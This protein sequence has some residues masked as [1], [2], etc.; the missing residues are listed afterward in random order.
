[1]D[2]LSPGKEAFYRFEDV[3]RTAEQQMTDKT[4]GVVCFG[5]DILS[6]QIGRSGLRAGGGVKQQRGVLGGHE[7]G[8]SE[9]GD[10]YR[11]FPLE[12]LL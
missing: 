6:S 3:P 2:F 10:Y 11:S 5:D 1:M 4:A 8:R 7:C 9:G 12:S